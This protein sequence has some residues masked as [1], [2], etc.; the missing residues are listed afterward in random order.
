MTKLIKKV[1]L[2]F[3][4]DNSQHADPTKG[5]QTNPYTQEEMAQLL[6][7]DGWQGGYVESVGH[8]SASDLWDSFSEDHGSDEWAEFYAALALVLQSMP[9]SLTSLVSS[10]TVHIYP[11]PGRASGGYYNPNTKSIYLA[12]NSV[13]KDTVRH[14]LI[15]AWEDAQDYSDGNNC[16]GNREFETYV[17]NDLAGLASG[18][19]CGS[20]T[21]GEDASEPYIAFLVSCFDDNNHFDRIRFAGGIN[22]FFSRFLIRHPDNYDPSYQWHWDDLLTVFG[23]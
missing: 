13:D 11:D 7:Q 6:A 16:H 3:E 8:V 21:M 15:H 12:P 18:S 20:S 17:M 14:E 10:E 22:G 5:T 4:Q 19:G 9:T 1:Q 2:T 23:L